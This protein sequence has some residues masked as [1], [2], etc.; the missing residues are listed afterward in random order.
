MSAVDTLLVFPFFAGAARLAVRFAGRV[1]KYPVEGSGEKTGEW[2]VGILGASGTGVNLI[3]IEILGI[4]ASGAGAGMV[5]DLG[6]S[7]GAGAGAGVGANT[8]AGAGE[9]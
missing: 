2:S 4:E 1:I 7:T 6:V 5:E 8:G 9:N 3:R